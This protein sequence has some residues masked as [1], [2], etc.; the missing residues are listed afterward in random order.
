MGKKIKPITVK[1]LKEILNEYDENFPLVLYKDG[2]GH[3]YPIL[4]DDIKQVTDCYFP[5]SDVEE[6]DEFALQIG[7]C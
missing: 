3:F 2:P 4:L 1:E 6:I 5:D 7:V